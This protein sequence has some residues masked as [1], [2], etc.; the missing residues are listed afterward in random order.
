MLLDIWNHF[1]IWHTLVAVSIRADNPTLLLSV[2]T[3]KS[4][5]AQNTNQ[6]DLG[7]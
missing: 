3:N 1:S 5:E 2:N 6:L 7:T 4:I